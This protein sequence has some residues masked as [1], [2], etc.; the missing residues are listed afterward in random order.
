[1]ITEALRASVS[2]VPAKQASAFSNQATSLGMIGRLLSGIRTTHGCRRAPSRSAQAQRDSPSLQPSPGAGAP[3]ADPQ[4]AS[5]I[6]V[7]SSSLDDTW[8][9]RDIGAVPSS[10][11]TR[12]IDTAASPS[13]SATRTAAATIRPRLRDGLGPLCGR[14]RTPQ[15]AATLPGSPAAPGSG[16]PD[17]SPAAPGSGTPDASPAAPGSGTPDA[18]PAA[19][20]SGTP[21]ASP[22]APGSA[23]PDASPAAPG[24]GTPDASP[25]AP[26]SATPDGSPVAPGSGSASATSRAPPSGPPALDSIIVLRIAYANMRMTYAVKSLRVNRGVNRHEQ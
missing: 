15:A 18:S 16:T 23:T 24:S 14:S 25:A 20:G 17:A 6:T 3:G 5:T 7:S 26:G 10:P 12:P 2:P 13:V 19:P 22:A 9:Y 1:M 21:D 8:R 4:A 11:A